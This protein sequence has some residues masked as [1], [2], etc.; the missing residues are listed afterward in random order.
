VTHFTDEHRAKAEITN[1]SR[2]KMKNRAEILKQSI[3]DA[4]DKGLSFEEVAK[5]CHTSINKVRSILLDGVNKAMRVQR[6][7]ESLI[8]RSAKGIAVVDQWLDKGDKDVAMWL[9]KETGIVG[10]EQ[11]NITINAQNAQI[12]TLSN[13]TLEAARA[14]AELMRAPAVRR[15]LQQSNDIVVEEEESDEQSGDDVG[16]TER[17]GITENNNDINGNPN[18]DKHGE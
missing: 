5:E 15:Q 16:S 11:T 2:R 9:L 18:D 14:V 6:F 1:R 10:K 17:L 13:D 3:L 4:R 7:N 12:N 8:A